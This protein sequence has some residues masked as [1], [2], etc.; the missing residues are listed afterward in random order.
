MK[1]S[2]EVSY[3]PILRYLSNSWSN[4]PVNVMRSHISQL[5]IAPLLFAEAS[6]LVQ[7]ARQDVERAALGHGWPVAA[8]RRTSGGGLSFGDFSL[9][10]Q[11][12]VTRPSPKG[13]RNPFEASGL[14]SCTAKPCHSPITLNGRLRL[15]ANRPYDSVATLAANV[16]QQHGSNQPCRYDKGR[17]GALCH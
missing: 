13:G 17:R 7:A 5:S 1:V 15:T 9:A 8:C 12:K 3:F 11:R 4:F 14:A 2:S 10:T 6:P 16:F